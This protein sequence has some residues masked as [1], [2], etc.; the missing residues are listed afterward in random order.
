[1]F[2]RE[3]L[4]E[5]LDYYTSTA[6]LVLRGP[7]RSNWKTTSC[8]FHGGSDSF[9]VNIKTGG[10]ICF[11]CQA[12]GGDILAYHMAAHGLSFVEAAKALGAYQEGGKQHSGNTRP[13]PIAARTLLE[14]VA[15]ELTVASIVASDI[16]RGRAVGTTDMD[17]LVKAAGR[18]GYVAEVAN[19]K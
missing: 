5:P 3:A 19:A 2:N 16:A 14:S 13:T 12:K 6:G 9:S 4:P 7:T 18:I 17:R 1:M 11:N 15:H 10:F 8:A